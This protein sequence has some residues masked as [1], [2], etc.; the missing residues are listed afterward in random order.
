MFTIATFTWP[1]LPRSGLGLC[2]WLGEHLGWISD[3]SQ[4]DRLTGVPV[5]S[6]KVVLLE[7]LRSLKIPPSGRLSGQATGRRQ[8]RLG[9]C[10][11]FRECSALLNF[12]GV[13]F[14]E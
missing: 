4:A 8:F 9:G 3:R 7:P 14:A 10:V 1:K 13:A 12:H 2:P 11:E 5:D 6:G